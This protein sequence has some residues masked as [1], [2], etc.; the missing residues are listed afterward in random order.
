MQRAVLEYATSLQAGVRAPAQDPLV[1]F[2]GTLDHDEAEAMWA[3]VQ[4]SCRGIEP[5]GW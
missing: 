1:D 5:V 2:R 3:V 4:E